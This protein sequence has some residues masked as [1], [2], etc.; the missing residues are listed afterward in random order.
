VAADFSLHD[1]INM[2]C[3]ERRVRH[4]DCLSRIFLKETGEHSPVR[5]KMA[6]VPHVH[7][8]GLWSGRWESTGQ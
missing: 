3:S 2:C 1:L 7:N 8:D 5:E 6:G 4:N